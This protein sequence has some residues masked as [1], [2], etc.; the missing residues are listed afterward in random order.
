MVPISPVVG[1]FRRI[2][3]DKR[4]CV[5]KSP[6]WSANRKLSGF[7]GGISPDKS[8]CVYPRFSRHNPGPKPA[9]RR[10]PLTCDATIKANIHADT[11]W[12]D[13]KICSRWPSTLALS[14]T[15]LTVQG[16]SKEHTPETR[17]PI[18]GQPSQGSGQRNGNSCEYSHYSVIEKRTHSWWAD[19]PKA[20]T[21]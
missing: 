17:C 5:G 12:K 3:N 13:A 10:S 7:H 9:S 11:L 21:K 16:C 15:M 20:G 1:K 8:A 4:A 14:L 2:G 19:C 18:D 6:G